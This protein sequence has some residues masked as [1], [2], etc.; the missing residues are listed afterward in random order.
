MY[1]LIEA[2]QPLWWWSWWW[3][4][5]MGLDWMWNDRPAGDGG[6]TVDSI[7]HKPQYRPRHDDKK[8]ISTFEMRTG[9]SFLRSH[10][11]R[12]EFL[13]FNL[14]IRHEKENRDQDNFCENVQ[15]CNFCLFLYWYFQESLLRMSFFSRNVYDFF[16]FFRRE[17]EYFSFNLVIRD[18][19]FFLSISCFKTRTRNRKLFLNVEQ[20]NIKLI[21]TRMFEIENSCQQELRNVTD[22]TDIGRLG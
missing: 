11:S 2:Q 4:T 17:R 3:A 19:N 14:G 7:S 9:I 12:Q 15:E 22:M 6:N 18:E 13:S 16:C 5:D 10:V 8:P 20:T 1:F 21:L